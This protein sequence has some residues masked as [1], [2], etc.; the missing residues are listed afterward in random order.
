LNQMEI[1]KFIDSTLL[2]PDATA[3]EVTR[4]CHEATRYGFAAV[5]V[6]SS[7][8]RLV[9]GLLAGSGV[10]TCVVVGFPLGASLTAVKVFE[11]ERAMDEGAQ[12]LDMVMNIGAFKSGDTVLALDDIKAVV[13]RCAGRALVKAI[14]ECS[15]LT[16]NEKARSCEM[17]VTAGA[18][19]VKTSTGFSTGGATVEDVRLLAR[20]AKGRV[21]VKASGGIKDLETALAMIDA[22]ADRL[23]TSNG[24]A[25][26]KQAGQSSS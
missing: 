4:L 2:R 20:T 18:D 7:H 15:L 14:L 8:T 6:N 21:K 12:E 26:A 10:K 16:N 9:S 1:N 24:A 19:F 23:G 11:A 22:G 13:E 25:I 3:D 17:A 5:C